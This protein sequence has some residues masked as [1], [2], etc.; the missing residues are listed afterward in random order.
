M[1]S[2]LLVATRSPG[3][4]REIETILALTERDLAFPEDLGLWQRP[5]EGGLE[6][7]ESF[8]GN[9]RRKAEYFVR[10]TGLET[11]ADDS[12]LEVFALGGQPGVRS[13]RFA[14]YD[15]PPAGLDAANNAEL[16]KRL[17]GAPPERRRAQYRCVAVYLSGASANPRAFEG[18]CLG[19]VLQAPR[20][21]GGFG[22]D[23]LFLSDELGM[24]FGEA[25]PH[26]KHAVSH[27]GRAFRGFA[28][29]LTRQRRD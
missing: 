27:R 5:E 4:R 10:L 8:E 3:K 1:T 12:G 16:L 11:V 2:R 25:E 14:L 19:R 17:A 29:W 7:A 9:A 20:G 23:P 24:T 21:V 15:G 18:T 26:A 22:Y 6:T 28:D 13:R